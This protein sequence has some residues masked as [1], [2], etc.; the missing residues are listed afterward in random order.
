[1]GQSDEV[2]A[3]VNLNVTFANNYYYNSMDR[4]PRLRYGTAHVYNCIMD[5]QELLDA[6][7]S[8]K[9]EAAAKH[10]VSNGAASTCNGEVLLENC[11]INGIQNALNSGNGSSPSGYIKAVDTLYYVDGVRYAPIP[12]VNTTKEGEQL[13]LTDADSFKG[14]L[15]YSDYTLFDAAKLDTIVKPYAGAGKLSL[16]TLQWEKASYNDAN[17][18]KPTDNKDYDADELPEYQISV[19]TPTPTPTPVPGEADDDDDSS[20]D[21]TAL[22]PAPVPTPTPVL[23]P[24]NSEKKPTDTAQ[25]D[26][27]TAA[28]TVKKLLVDKDMD[29]DNVDKVLNE[30]LKE[31]GNGKAVLEVALGKYHELSVGIVEAIKGKDVTLKMTQSNGLIWEINGKDITNPANVN[32]KVDLTSKPIP[33]DKLEIFKD[34]ESTIQFSLEHNGDFGFKATMRFPTGKNAEG[35]YA[36]LF[37]FNNGEFEFMESSK[38]EKGY[39]D[40]TFTHASD[41]VVVISEAAMSAVPQVKAEAA[42]TENTGKNEAAS[43]NAGN[44]ASDSSRLP[45]ILIIIAAL[46]VGGIAIGV[47]VMRKKKEE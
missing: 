6:R 14:S 32:M 45:I 42:V 5:A 26:A 41:Y 43:G 2:T 11:Y 29:W 15:P 46:V 37:Y 27:Q 9:N 22:T 3:N 47:V 12:K 34:A 28:E 25:T 1:M 23:A 20:S 31:A 40:F 16:T 35:K 33:A 8:I 18:Q 17:F 44:T 10:I 13:K 19:P 36:N 4:M 7:K 21:T 24:T 39:A 30:L 38:V